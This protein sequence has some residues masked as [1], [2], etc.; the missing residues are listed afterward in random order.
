VVAVNSV[1]G[2][3]PIHE[4]EGRKLTPGEETKRLQSWFESAATSHSK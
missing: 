4:V 2:I 3:V 1:R